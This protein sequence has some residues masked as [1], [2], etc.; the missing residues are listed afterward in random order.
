MTGVYPERSEGLAGR[1]ALVTGGAKR[2]GAAIASA[3]E[4]AGAHVLVTSR[5]APLSFDLSTRDGVESLLAALPPID[6]LVNAAANF[7]REP[8]GSITFENFDATFA[9]NA[10]APLFL[11]QTLGLAMK[12]RGYGRIVNIAD[13]AA[14]IP[15]PAYL[16]YSMSNSRGRYTE[17]ASQFAAWTVIPSWP[18]VWS[19]GWSECSTEYMPGPVRS[20]AASWSNTTRTR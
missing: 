5:S 16:P 20:L 10:R 14:T 6:L 15:W 17:R 3:L 13:I 18:G 8:F 9:L 11:S 2:V 4:S 1:T 7:I 19:S 12:E